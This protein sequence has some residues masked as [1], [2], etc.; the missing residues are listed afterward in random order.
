MTTKVSTSMLNQS[1]NLNIT[2]ANVSLG[3]VANIH[4]TGGSSG[5]ALI[6]DGAGNLSFSNAGSS[7]TIKDEGTTLNTAVTSIDFVGSS[8]TATN[9]GNA[10]TVTISGGG[11]T[12]AAVGYS[13]VFGG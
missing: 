2:A 6:T 5:Q 13:L 11:S 10:V 12:A 4:I 7:L 1:G 3:P 8:V 9:V